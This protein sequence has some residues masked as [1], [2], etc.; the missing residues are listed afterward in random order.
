MGISCTP[1]NIQ[2]YELNQKDLLQHKTV[3]LQRVTFQEADQGSAF[4]ENM[5]LLKTS[6]RSLRVTGDQMKSG[7]GSEENHDPK[8][9]NNQPLHP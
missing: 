9:D 2:C 5:A 6:V 7:P 4:R 1:K 8:K 3:T